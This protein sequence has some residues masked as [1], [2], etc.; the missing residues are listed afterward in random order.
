MIVGPLQLVL[1]LFHPY[2]NC[3][4][5]LQQL[6]RVTVYV[7]EII[8]RRVFFLLLLLFLFL[9]LSFAVSVL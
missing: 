6:G 2:C 8:R 1:F 5:I 3:A 4:P 7:A 9:I